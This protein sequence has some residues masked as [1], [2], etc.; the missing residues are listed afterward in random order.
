MNK[1]A[2]LDAENKELVGADEG[3]DTG[4]LDEYVGRMV[5]TPYHKVS[6]KDYEEFKKRVL[7]VEREKV[8]RQLMSKEDKERLNNVM[9]GSAFRK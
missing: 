8:D 4:A 7:K 3:A 2:E 6:R 9:I 1:E 5:G